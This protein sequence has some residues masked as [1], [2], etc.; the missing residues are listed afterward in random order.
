MIAFLVDIGRQ[1]QH[2][3]RTVSD[4]E[5]AAFTAF[6]DNDD[7]AQNGPGGIQVQRLSPVFRLFLHVTHIG[8]VNS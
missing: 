8:L 1:L 4:A 2:L 6:P 3:P 5:A 7:L